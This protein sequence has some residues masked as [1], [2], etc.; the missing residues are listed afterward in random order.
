MLPDAD[1][2]L[3]LQVANSDFTLNANG[4]LVAAGS[5]TL[6]MLDVMLAKDGGASASS[7]YAPLAG[8]RRL[9]CSMY[10]NSCQDNAYVA[11]WETRIGVT[12]DPSICYW[13]TYEFKRNAGACF[14]WWTHGK[15]T[16]TMGVT[17]T[18]GTFTTAT[19]TITGATHTTN[20]YQAQDGHHCSFTSF[21]LDSTSTLGTGTITVYVACNPPDVN[22]AFG[23]TTAVNYVVRC[24][25]CAR[26]GCAY[27]LFV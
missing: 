6:T 19:F 11:A 9:A 13:R 5:G 8:R 12:V 17:A 4:S 10:D 7:D 26:P 24:T 25:T 21:S 16:N 14:N 18:P 20:K 3:G 1:I 27:A 15:W 23:S 2:F 22:P